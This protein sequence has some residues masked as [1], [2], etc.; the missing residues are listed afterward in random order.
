VGY[1]LGNLVACQEYLSDY[2]DIT[3]GAVNLVPGEWYFISVDNDNSSGY[4]G[5]FTLCVDD[6]VDYD[7]REGAIELPHFPAWCSAEAIYTV[8]GRHRLTEMREAAG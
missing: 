2:E 5:T 1:D 6:A 3:M 4:R 8:P 7:F